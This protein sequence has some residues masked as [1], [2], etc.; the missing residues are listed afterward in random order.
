MGRKVQWT[1]EKLHALLDEFI[2]WA[3]NTD[4]YPSITNFIKWK[5]Q[6]RKKKTKSGSIDRLYPDF[7]KIYIPKYPSVKERWERLSIGN[8]FI[9]ELKLAYGIQKKCNPTLIKL[10]LAANH[11][12]VEKQELDINMKNPVVIKY[13]GLDDDEDE[14]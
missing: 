12:W 1:E 11:G 5:N 6:Q 4:L 10:D 8:T 3:E 7:F 2:D 13:I 14:K 9:P